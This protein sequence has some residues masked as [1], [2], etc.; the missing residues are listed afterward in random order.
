M[1]GGAY[2]GVG[3]MS[4]TDRAVGVNQAKKIGNHYAR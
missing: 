1:V 4:S 3:Y 2:E